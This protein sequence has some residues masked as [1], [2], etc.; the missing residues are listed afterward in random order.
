MKEGGKASLGRSFVSGIDDV[1]GLRGI[2]G[3]VRI[4][5]ELCVCVL[6]E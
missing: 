5:G 2:F 1:I 3:E 6:D 4:I